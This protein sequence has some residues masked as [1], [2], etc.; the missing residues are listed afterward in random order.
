MI[1]MFDRGNQNKLIGY[2]KRQ[3]TLDLMIT[4]RQWENSEIEKIINKNK[5]NK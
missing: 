4:L 1:A 2:F 5:D 3:D